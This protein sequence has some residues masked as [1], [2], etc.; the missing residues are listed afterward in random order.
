[1][2][3]SA[4]GVGS[5]VGHPKFGSGLIVSVDATYYKIYFSSIE[6]VKT[7]ARDF[8]GF[9][10]EEAKVPDFPVLTLKEV[11]KAIREAIKATSERAPLVP[12]GGKW[13]GGS[14]IIEPFDKNL[15]SKEIPIETFF[16]KIVMVREKL[17]VLEQNIN[18]LPK[19]DDEDRVG[20]QQYITRCYGSL[21]TFNALF[22]YKEDQFRGSG[23]G[24]V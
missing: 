24:E 23:K 15:Q 18:N 4:L 9:T 1:M 17:R 13:I 6:V 20:L 10:V 2:S 14:L 5:R 16:H 19:L 22:A 7:L 3:A 21:T 8:E 12:L 11:E